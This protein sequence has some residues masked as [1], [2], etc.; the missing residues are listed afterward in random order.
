MALPFIVAVLL[1][2]VSVVVTLVWFWSAL[3]LSRV[4]SSSASSWRG[5]WTEF[6]RIATTPTNMFFKGII[7]FINVAF[8][9]LILK[10][11]EM[12]KCTPQPDGTELLDASRELNCL[13]DW[14]PPWRMAA[15]IC[16]CVYAIGIP[17]LVGAVLFT[18]RP[19]NNTVQ[20]G[21]LRLPPSWV[22][23]SQ[24]QVAL[25][26][27]QRRESCIDEAAFAEKKAGIVAGGVASALSPTVSLLEKK[28][29][30]DTFVARYAGMTRLYRR[31]YFFWSLVVMTRNLGFSVIAVLLSDQPLQQ[32]I[33]AMM[34][35]FGSL[36]LHTLHRPYRSIMPFNELE[37]TAL[38]C[39]IAILFLGLS[40]Y[41]RAEAAVLFDEVDRRY[42]WV[43]TLFE[44]TVSLVVV[45]CSL[46]MAMLLWQQLQHTLGVKMAVMYKRALES[47]AARQARL[48]R[49]ERVRRASIAAERNKVV[50]LKPGPARAYM[51]DGKLNNTQEIH[52][53]VEREE[54][55]VDDSDNENVA[56]ISASVSTG[57]SPLRQRPR[58]RSAPSKALVVAGMGGAGK[59]ASK[60]DVAEQKVAE[61]DDEDGF[62][63]VR[64]NSKAFAAWS[65]ALEPKHHQALLAFAAAWRERRT[66]E[67]AWL[68]LWM[69]HQKQRAK[70]LSGGCIGPTPKRPSTPWPIMMRHDYPHSTPFAAPAPAALWASIMTPR[71]RLARAQEAEALLRMRGLGLAGTMATVASG[72]S[73]VAGATGMEEDD[74]DAE[75]AAVARELAEMDDDEF[76][77]L[78]DEVEYALAAAKAAA[79]GGQFTHHVD[80]DG[81]I[82]QTKKSRRPPVPPVRWP[83]SMLPTTQLAGFGLAVETDTGSVYGS[84]LPGMLSQATR[85]RA[86]GEK[87]LHGVIPS[88]ED[89]YGDGDGAGDEDDDDD[90]ED[91]EPN[92]ALRAEIARQQALGLFPRGGESQLIKVTRPPQ[93]Q[94]QVPQ[95]VID[96]MTATNLRPNRRTLMPTAPGHGVDATRRRADLPPLLGSSAQPLGLDAL[97]AVRPLIA[98]AGRT[99]PLNNQATQ[100]D[101]VTTEQL[102]TDA[103]LGAAA[104]HMLQLPAPL[105]LHAAADQSASHASSL[106][107][108]PT[109]PLPTPAP[110][111]LSPPQHLPASLVL[112]TLSPAQSVKAGKR[113]IVVPQTLVAP[114]IALAAGNS[115][116]PAPLVL[117]SPP[118]GVSVASASSPL[119]ASP[120]SASPLLAQHL[121]AVPLPVSVVQS[122]SVPKEHLPP[123]QMIRPPQPDLSPEIDA[124]T[125]PF[126]DKLIAAM[127]VPRTAVDAGELSMP[128]PLVL[129]SSTSPLS[130]LPVPPKLP[131]TLRVHLPQRSAPTAAQLSPPQRTHP[132]VS[133]RHT[134]DLSPRTPLSAK[135]GPMLS[136]HVPHMSPSRLHRSPSPP[137]SSSPLVSQ[138]H[139]QAFGAAP[140]LSSL[141]LAMTAEGNE[142]RSDENDASPRVLTMQPQQDLRVGQQQT[143]LDQSAR[144][145][146]ALHRQ[147]R[148]QQQA[149]FIASAPPAVSAAVSLGDS[150]SVKIHPK[151]PSPPP[152]NDA[153][154]AADVAD[155]PAGAAAIATPSFVM[156]TV[157]KRYIAPV[158]PM[159]A[160]V[161]M[162]ATTAHP[163]GARTPFSTHGSPT[164]VGRAFMDEHGVHSP[165]SP[166]VG[167]IAG[168]SASPRVA[169]A[170]S[171]SS[172]RAPKTLV[173]AAA[174]VAAGL[175]GATES[176][177]AVRPMR[178]ASAAPSSSAPGLPLVSPPVRT[179]A[180]S[181]Q[182]QQDFFPNA[183]V[184]AHLPSRAALSSSPSSPMSPHHIPPVPRPLVIS[185]SGASVALRV[186]SEGDASSSSSTPSPRVE[187]TASS[188]AAAD[189]G[190]PIHALVDSPRMPA[191]LVI[192]QRGQTMHREA[193]S[194]LASAGVAA[195]GLPF[196]MTTLSLPSP[197]VS[198]PVTS[199]MGALLSGAG[200]RLRNG[201][202]FPSTTM[203]AASPSL[204]DATPWASRSPAAA[205]LTASCGPLPLVSPT[206]S[207]L[208]RARPGP[209][210]PVAL[211]FGQMSVPT[212]VQPSIHQQLPGMSPVE[213]NSEQ[214]RRDRDDE[215][216]RNPSPNTIDF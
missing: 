103:L 198:T 91:G 95:S 147:Q 60:A 140:L 62:I 47:P 43:S 33:L 196:A 131:K 201:S 1:A 212:Q 15:I 14:Y 188:V 100:Q 56:D 123:L 115:S 132:D 168:F 18:R 9:A 39:E 8:L 143:T 165:S 185:S 214:E 208:A 46:A 5:H 172:P 12:L 144:G 163:A 157:A 148:L 87:D 182:S 78:H 118:V 75:A 186:V 206:S 44:T 133:P 69:A 164:A 25:V 210:P 177:D 152:S 58:P 203:D 50:L 98:G 94:Q 49:E 142:D 130:P 162:G 191:P 184:S 63:G 41:S 101:D 207:V 213:D 80:A 180:F 7:T 154:I 37:T 169:A 200:A 128:K 6:K 30:M 17:L 40:F 81:R 187:T 204:L 174:D 21:L 139:V 92:V 141:A 45:V 110:L 34:L 54:S 124:L 67:A 79:A 121:P 159:T 73:A 31:D 28:Q 156:P 158:R 109:P 166:G 27:A 195:E 52:A 16:C 138:T 108:L 209:L 2:V 35:L 137:P 96:L 85:G 66:N 215:E 178:P 170:F 126:S 189:G 20:W 65:S 127:A 181:V 135:A 84:S 149:Q 153:S 76:I 105:V 194:T 53:G 216:D 86:G 151:V 59:R 22:G 112:T 120:I 160:Q 57:I 32:A 104:V 183:L 171:S 82:L 99:I 19:L 173:V 167:R 192:P 175:A 111:V 106:V 193:P 11:L 146:S 190:A 36:L 102:A 125:S 55:D 107:N 150:V 205:G 4:S 117:T 29:S 24:Q 155:T 48:V 93:Q 77:D 119:S 70:W 10:A 97:G 134:F 88:D 197:P 145:M 129:G 122:T 38:S 71:T 113:T 64:K 23:Y 3:V 199:P 61:E 179:L 161:R 42:S 72:S 114:S 90:E 211:N 89:E 83:S 74:E 26:R 51:I 13:D 136:S 68:T 116:V 176:T 202:S